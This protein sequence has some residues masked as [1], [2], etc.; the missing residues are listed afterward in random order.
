MWSYMI[1][2]IF[3]YCVLK[4]Y[5]DCKKCLLLKLHAG[6]SDDIIFLKVRRKKFLT[7]DKQ[8]RK[9]EQKWIKS[10]WEL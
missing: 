9:D 8:Q 7:F 4:M 5:T 6:I 2:Y 1:V 10:K 3:V